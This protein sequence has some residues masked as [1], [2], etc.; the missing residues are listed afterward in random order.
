MG[1]PTMP[2]MPPTRRRIVVA[3]TM[4]LLLA[5]AACGDDDGATVRDVPA[6]SDPGSGSGA[7][8]DG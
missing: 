1:R 6:P 7:S 3:A 8:T 4:P 2:V 5:L